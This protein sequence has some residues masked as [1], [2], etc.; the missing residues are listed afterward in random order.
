IERGGGRGMHRLVGKR[1]GVADRQRFGMEEGRDS[2][3]SMRYIF[4]AEYVLGW[5]VMW[6][7]T[8][9]AMMQPS[10]GALE[11]KCWSK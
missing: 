10:Q 5:T 3:I 9:E 2:I 8:S 6:K 1:K 11:F 4:Y 7:N